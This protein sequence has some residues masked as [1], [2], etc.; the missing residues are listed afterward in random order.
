[1]EDRR[2]VDQIEGAYILA[3]LYTLGYLGMMGS[4]MFV[5]IPEA[6][7][8]LLLT[9]AG[10]MSA[11]QL[12]IIKYYYDGSQG[13]AKAQIANIA[14]ASHAD[15]VIQDIAKAAPSVAAAVVAAAATPSP[16]S[17]PQ[18]PIKADNVNVSADTVNVD[19]PKKDSP[20]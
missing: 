17:V 5:P 13:A 14:R 20:P 3:I 15:V 6:N 18:E 12:G 7:K 8:E 11:A 4:L 16:A 10:I 9:L 19:T 1:M 2:V